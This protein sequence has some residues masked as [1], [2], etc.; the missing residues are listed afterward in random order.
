MVW[1]MGV[2]SGWE[3]PVYMSSGRGIIQQCRCPS[4]VFFTV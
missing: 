3:S 4:Q 2:V 1:N